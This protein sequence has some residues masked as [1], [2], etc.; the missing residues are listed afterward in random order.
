MRFIVLGLML[1]AVSLSCA[2]GM[3]AL[4]G[5]NASLAVKFN[6]IQ[7]EKDRL[8]VCAIL[9][10]DRTLDCVDY[11]FFQKQLNEQPGAGTMMKKYVEGRK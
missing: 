9:R 10:N 2:A 4:K 3:N 7:Q 11:M 8:Y 1:I 6:G 5:D